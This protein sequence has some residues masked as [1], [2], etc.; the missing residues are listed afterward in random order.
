M[1]RLLSSS[2]GLVS[3]SSACTLR[4]RRLLLMD[5]ALALLHEPDS[6]G[7]PLP[8]LHVLEFISGG[9]DPPLHLTPNAQIQQLFPHGESA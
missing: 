2:Q 8:R 3:L 1:R 5:D 4:F 7:T 6:H 9:A